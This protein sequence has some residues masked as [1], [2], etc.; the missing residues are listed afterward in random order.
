MQMYE[1]FGLRVG[2]IQSFIWVA[3]TWKEWGLAFGSS[4]TGGQPPASNRASV[5]RGGASISGAKYSLV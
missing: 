5:G 1:F 3:L 2:K 4:A